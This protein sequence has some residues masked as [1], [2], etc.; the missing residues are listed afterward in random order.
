MGPANQNSQCMRKARV[1][2]IIAC[3]I[4]EKMWIKRKR[5]VTD[6]VKLKQQM[7]P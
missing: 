1:F 3:L 2:K 4:A 5:K 7:T 6:R